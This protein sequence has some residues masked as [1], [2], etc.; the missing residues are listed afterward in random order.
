MTYDVENILKYLKQWKK[1][2]DKFINNK[3]KRKLLC[4]EPA[5]FH[6]GGE[7][8]PNWAT[9]AVSVPSE[10]QLYIAKQLHFY[11]PVWKM[12]HIMLSRLVLVHLSVNFFVSG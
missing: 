9:G 5:T 10:K 12:G 2:R 8:S 6:V 3:K 7:G 1:E 4:F 11:T